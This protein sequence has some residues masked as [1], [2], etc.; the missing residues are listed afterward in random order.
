[1]LQSLPVRFDCS[2]RFLI[3][4]EAFEQDG[5]LHM[6]TGITEFKRLMFLLDFCTKPINHF[7]LNTGKIRARHILPDRVNIYQTKPGQRL[8][9][10]NPRYLKRRHEAVSKS[11]LRVSPLRGTHCKW[12]IW[13]IVLYTKNDIY[14]LPR[15]LR[16]HHARSIIAA[17]I[18]LS[19]YNACIYAGVSLGG[20]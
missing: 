18:R 1:M 11:R 8:A 10:D 16:L 19:A 20:E 5:S 7:C 3:F 14:L 9:Q 13:I 6:L 17:R 12:C 15:T 4:G 2:G